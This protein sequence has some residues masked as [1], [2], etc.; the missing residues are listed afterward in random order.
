M[1]DLAANPVEQHAGQPALLLEPVLRFG[2]RVDTLDQQQPVIT[3]LQ[4]FDLERLRLAIVAL[5]L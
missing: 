1:A 5:A 2:D 3:V 4:I